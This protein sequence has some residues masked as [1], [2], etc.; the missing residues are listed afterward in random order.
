MRELEKDIRKK[1]QLGSGYGQNA[2]DMAVKEL[3]NHV[4]RIRNNVYGYVQH[5]HP[6]MELYISYISLLNASVLNMD[7]MTTIEGLLEKEEQKKKPT[8]SKLEEYQN[9]LKE[10]TSFGEEKREH[11]KETVAALFMDKFMHWK[12][13]FVTCA[14]LQLDSR[15][16]TIEKSHSTKEDFI[17]SVKLLGE[18]DRVAFPVSASR[19]GLRRM[20]QYKTGSMTIKLMESGKVRIGVPFTKKIEKKKIPKKNILSFDAGITDLI[21]TNTG[22]S[23][24][25]FHGMRQLYEEL[26][27]TK[28]GNRSSL[29]NK[30]REYQKELKRN[31]NPYE[32]ER[33]RRKIRHIARSLNG[34]KKK[35][36]CL[37]QYAHQADLRINEV[38]KLFIEEVRKTNSICV[39]E[40]LDITEFDRGKKNNKRDSMWVRGQLT[41]KIQSKLDWL[42]IVHMAVDPAYTSKM[43]P[44]CFHI[45]D[46]NRNGKSFIC[47]VCNH[48]DDADHN[49][50]VNIGQR[51]FDEE[52][53]E[54]VEKYKYNTKKRHEAIKKLFEQRHRSFMGNK[55]AA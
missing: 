3:H 37:R 25:T 17:V 29:R 41:K 35:N 55:P 13:P 16:S 2:V 40:D 4:I 18:K 9:L 24:G 38:V 39:Y 33:L 32:K 12:L 19:N 52:M 43:C 22:N 51:A 26:V 31:T 15:L 34:K 6:E 8:Q 36:Q 10:I 14:P 54:I 49:A 20:S 53:N 7:E 47:T 42:G 50:A 1:H 46:K 11:Y 44:K 30:M 45:H 28:L 5:H 23:Y 21:Y 27:E 48:K